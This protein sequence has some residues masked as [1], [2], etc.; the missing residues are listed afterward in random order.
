MVLIADVLKGPEFAHDLKRCQSE[1]IFDTD[2]IALINDERDW[3]QLGLS[4]NAKTL[5]LQ[6]CGSSSTS[7]EAEIKPVNSIVTDPSQIAILNKH[8]IVDTVD[9][10]LLSDSDWEL[11]KSEGITDETRNALLIAIGNPGVFSIEPSEISQYLKD[12]KFSTDLLILD[13]EM[14]YTLEDVYRLEPEDWQEL[15]DKRLIPAAKAA[16][17]AA[18]PPAPVPLQGRPTRKT[19]ISSII[20]EK[21]FFRDRKKLSE[22]SL[23]IMN[24]VMDESILSSQ[25]ISNPALNKIREAVRM[26]LEDEKPK[27]P[28]Y[29]IDNCFDQYYQRD[30]DKNIGKCKILKKRIAVLD[31]AIRCSHRIALKAEIEAIR[32][33][34]EVAKLTQLKRQLMC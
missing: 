30:L 2:D 10:E 32:R 18:L 22:N 33:A 5:L 34:E 23:D 20:Y 15:S 31:R 24:H 4:S 14:I 17:L 19:K 26:I 9:I 3:Q 12:E 8:L 6:S 13:N 28:L 7:S 11:L 21:M 1:L 27:E 29:N 16:L 25:E